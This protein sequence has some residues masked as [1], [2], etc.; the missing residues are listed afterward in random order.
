MATITTQDK[1]SIRLE[2][3][4]HSFSEAVLSEAIASGVGVEVEIITPRT[5]LMPVE[6]ELSPAEVLR[7]AGL[8]PLATECAVA[9]EAHDGRVAVLA[10]DS[11]LY[12][13]ITASE[14][15][16]CTSPLSAVD[17][18]RDGVTLNLSGSVVYIHIVEG[19]E[20]RVAEA[21]EVDSDADIVYYLERLNEVYLIYN[22]TAYI[23]G[24][25]QRVGSLIKRFFKSVLC[26]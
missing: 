19:G 17:T 10:V 6:V 12:G 16:V 9:C 15:V 2:S 1:V 22:K 25:I 20:L 26:E 24:D 5:T 23:K 13:I 4:G 14:D 21:L 11:A 7:M 8:A 3:G 18:S